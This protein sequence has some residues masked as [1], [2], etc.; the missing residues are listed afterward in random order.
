MKKYIVSLI[1]III[2]IGCGVAYNIIGSEIAADGTLV[3]P[4]FLI[5][6]SFIFCLIG[7][8]IAM[9]VTIKSFVLKSKVVKK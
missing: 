4:F 7:L 1:F 2:G 6:F 5:P 8:I 3:E 9:V